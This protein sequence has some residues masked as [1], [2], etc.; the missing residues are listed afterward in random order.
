MVKACPGCWCCVYWIESKHLR[1]RDPDKKARTVAHQLKILYLR[2]LA[3]MLVGHVRP[4]LGPA[5]S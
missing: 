3:V 4:W 2:Q 1:R 5:L